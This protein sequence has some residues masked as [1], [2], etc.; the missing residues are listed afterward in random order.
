LEE[1]TRILK[2]C[3]KTTNT[4]RSPLEVSK[5]WGT[6]YVVNNLFKIYFQVRHLSSSYNFT[7]SL[8]LFFFV[9]IKWNH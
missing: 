6:L 9:A 8:S 5:R 3:F 2:N 1:T 7:L 4:D